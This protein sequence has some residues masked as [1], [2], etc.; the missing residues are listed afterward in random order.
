MEFMTEQDNPDLFRDT[1]CD[2]QG[3]PWY[4]REHSWQARTPYFLLAGAKKSAT[5][6]LSQYLGQHSRLNIPRAKELRFFL[7]KRFQAYVNN[8]SQTLVKNARDRM[9]TKDYNVTIT[10]Q[11]A[12]QYAFE[13]TPG[14]I[15]H[16]TRSPKYVLCA[17]PVGENCPHSP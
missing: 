12:T 8:A 15:F 10:Q 7:P 4:Y 3:E 2:L 13:A 14:Y 16:S 1:F 11:D 6:S 17:A 9:W 5:T